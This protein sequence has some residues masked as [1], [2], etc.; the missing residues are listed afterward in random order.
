MWGLISE[1]I[2]AILSTDIS[3][4]NAPRRSEFECM[5]IRKEQKLRWAEYDR[6]KAIAKLNKE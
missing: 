3:D 6:A 5:E 1:I 2:I 4:K